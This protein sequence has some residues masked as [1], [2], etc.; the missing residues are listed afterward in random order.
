MPT[1]ADADLILKLY[2]LRREA[3]MRKARKFV[4]E[5]FWPESAD[6]V[7]KIVQG[8]GSQ[9]NSWLRQVL[10]YWEMVASFVNK[11]ILDADLLLD[12]AGEMWFVYAKF[13]P[14]LPELRK[15][16]HS[17]IMLSIEKAAE[18]TQRGRERLDYMKTAFEKR[19]QMM[20][21]AQKA[22]AGA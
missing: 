11:G 18:S 12:S 1:H 22:P 9:E 4:M 6:E 10:G 20:A 17:E 2:D 16:V 13:K 14:L 21:Q 15:T 5:Q 3:E 8:F 7:L 19:K